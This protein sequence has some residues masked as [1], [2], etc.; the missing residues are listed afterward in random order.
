[1]YIIFCLVFPPGLFLLLL[2]PWVIVL[3]GAKKRVKTFD[4]LPPLLGGVM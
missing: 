2:H 4:V 3:F 1:M